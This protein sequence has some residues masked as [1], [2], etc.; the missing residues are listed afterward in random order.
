MS[1]ALL[2]VWLASGMSFSQMAD[3]MLTTVYYEE[4]NPLSSED[5]GIVLYKTNAKETIPQCEEMLNCQELSL[6]ELWD[7]WKKHMEDQGYQVE[8][9]EAKKANAAVRVSRYSTRMKDERKNNDE[10]QHV[11]NNR[12]NV[13]CYLRS[14]DGSFVACDNREVI[15]LNPKQHVISY[16]EPGIRA[17]P[18]KVEVS[19]EF[20][21]IHVYI[22][23]K[24]GRRPPNQ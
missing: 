7:L 3:I 20:K 8:E 17:A 21:D 10:K 14:L 9:C 15:L 12:G 23:V 2:L 16:Y 13:I 11:Y 22:T 24:R 6:T 4:R 5:S 19:T 18:K 1:F